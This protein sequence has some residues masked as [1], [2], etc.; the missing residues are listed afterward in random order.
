[1]NVGTAIGYIGVTVA[2]LVIAGWWLRSLIFFL[3][4]AAR[5]QPLPKPRAGVTILM[6]CSLL[7]LEVSIGLLN[8]EVWYRELIPV[9]WSSK[10]RTLTVPAPYS[11]FAYVLV[12]I[13]VIELR[14]WKDE[15]G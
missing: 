7:L 1:M 15:D 12:V 8:G 9:L 11:L 2:G 4:A 5:K 6:G 13:G 14:L 10:D 3:K